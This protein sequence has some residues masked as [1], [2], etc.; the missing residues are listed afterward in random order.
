MSTKIMR[1]R[2]GRYVQVMRNDLIADGDAYS[3]RYFEFD[4]PELPVIGKKY[5]VWCSAY[6]GPNPQQHRDDELHFSDAAEMVENGMPGNMNRNICRFHGWRGTSDDWSVTAI[7]VRF[8]ESVKRT[9]F[10]KTVCYRIAFGPD[11][12]AE[13]D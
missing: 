9:E 5:L 4:E 7:G 8:C 6:A 2:D 10:K 3:R 11:L 13:R 12:V 1:K